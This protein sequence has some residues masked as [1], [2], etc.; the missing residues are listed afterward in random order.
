MVTFDEWLKIMKIEF[1]GEYKKLFELYAN[2]KNGGKMN[3]REFLLVSCAL[4]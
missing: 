3:I 2:D 1:T 4:V